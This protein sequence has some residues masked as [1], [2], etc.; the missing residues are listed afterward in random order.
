[1]HQAR[2]SNQFISRVTLE[3][4]PFHHR[5]THVHIYLPDM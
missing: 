1:M 3:I 4:Q 2:G 5:V